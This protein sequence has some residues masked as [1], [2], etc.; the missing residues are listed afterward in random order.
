MGYLLPYRGEHCIVDGDIIKAPDFCK[1][2]CFL[3]KCQCFYEALSV[4]ETNR[5]VTCP[6]GL[7]VY[8]LNEGLF[9]HYFVGLREKETYNKQLAARLGKE[10][11]ERYNPVLDGTTLQKMINI[12]LRTEEEQRLV[13]EQKASIDSISHEAKKL[14]A[15]IKDR[16]GIIIQ[17]YGVDE[18]RNLDAEETQR[19]I[20]KIK[21]IFI[22]S[23]MVEARFSMLNYEKNPH[24]LA[25]G[26]TVDCNVYK[27]F[28]KMRKVF[29]NY[30][31]RRVPINLVGNS[32]K[33]IKAYPTFDMIPLLLVE[34][35]IKYSYQNN[36]VTITFDVEGDVLTVD[37]LSYSPYCS[38][39]EIEHIFEKGF[40][41]KNAMRAASGSGI[42]LFFV[43]MLCDLHKIDI[44]ISSDGTKIT[45]IDRVA[46]APYNVKLVLHDTYDEYA[47][48]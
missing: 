36:T 19:L 5:F 40:R 10:K 45:N 9:R 48:Y 35:A 24:V 13:N 39:E 12:S 34:N 37:I 28:D 22:C 4:T 23:S 31:G 20:E 27:K 46:Y 30:L 29:S 2:H 41:G 42:G 1:R 43:K 25:D 6:Y 26:A 33:C 38:K 16:S 11:N 18:K 32:Y 8:V 7:S 14:N 44:Y 47:G 21:T 17:E 3:G 15:Q